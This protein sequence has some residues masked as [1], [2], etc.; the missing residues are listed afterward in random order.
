M[1]RHILWEEQVSDHQI[2]RICN[3][4]NCRAQDVKKTS[5][6]S[7]IFG[8]RPSAARGSCG[9]SGMSRKGECRI[10]GKMMLEQGDVSCVFDAT[11][12]QNPLGALQ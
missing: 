11:P 10:L 9:R 2:S 7:A 4:L 8:S 12:Q 5:N 1:A 3:Y 6:R